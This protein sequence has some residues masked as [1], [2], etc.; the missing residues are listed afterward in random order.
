[1]K[2]II[3]FLI[4]I[5]LLGCTTPIYVNDEIVKPYGVF[6]LLFDKDTIHEDI[7]YGL[8]IGNIF[9][10]VVLIETVVVPFII[11]GWY[12]WQPIPNY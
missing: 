10:S 3:L 7:V 9:W 2:K 12:L 6:H 4:I 11:V 5:S 1:M 8:S